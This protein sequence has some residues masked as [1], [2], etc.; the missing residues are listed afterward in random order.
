VKDVTTPLSLSTVKVAFT[1][2]FELGKASLTGP[3]RTGAIVIITSIPVFD[4]YPFAGPNSV[5]AVE[6]HS[7]PQFTGAAGLLVE[8]QW[9]LP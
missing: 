6:W 4:Y 9:A 7:H 1:S 2:G 8:K 3:G 5:E